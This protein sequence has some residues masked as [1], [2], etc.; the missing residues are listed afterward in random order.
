MRAAGAWLAGAARQPYGWHQAGAIRRVHQP[1]VAEPTPPGH[2]PKCPI[3]VADGGAWLAGSVVCCSPTA[4]VA[5]PQDI[6][7][8]AGVPPAVPHPCALCPLSQATQE[9]RDWHQAQMRVIVQTITPA[10]FL[11]ARVH[12][13]SYRCNKILLPFEAV[14]SGPFHVHVKT[15]AGYTV[16][17]SV[18]DAMYHRPMGAFCQRVMYLL[19]ACGPLLGPTAFETT[20]T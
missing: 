5:A 7:V 15:L 8:P 14:G 4:L 18:D 2:G 19:G 12:Y 1:V 10:A 11:P 3:V 6:I 13:G 17:V 20:R 9:Q 16:S